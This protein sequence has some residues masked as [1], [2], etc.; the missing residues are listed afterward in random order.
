[1]TRVVERNEWTRT[2]VRWLLPTAA[3]SITLN[4]VLGAGLAYQVTLPPQ[5]KYFLQDTQT[6]RLTPVRPL[7]EPL[8]MDSNVTTW[9]SEA[10]S[11]VLSLDFVHFRQTLAAARHHFTQPGFESFIKA[12]KDSGNLDVLEANKQ[13]MS[14]SA[15]AAP[16]VTAKGVVSGRHVWKIKVPLIVTTHTGSSKNTARMTAVLTVLRT[17]PQENSRGYAINQVILKSGSEVR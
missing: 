8:V 6:G 7:N 4:L 1:M 15:T 3:V 12:M 2:A 13:V 17:T 9:A 10:M 14:A 11:E 16:V 5:A